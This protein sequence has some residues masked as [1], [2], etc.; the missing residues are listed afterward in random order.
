MPTF[1]CIKQ[2]LLLTNMPIINKYASEGMELLTQNLVEDI[3]L[4]WVFQLEVDGEEVCLRLVYFYPVFT[5]IAKLIQI[6]RLLVLL[7]YN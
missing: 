2:N 1:W 5:E 3:P 4:P 6:L 7:V